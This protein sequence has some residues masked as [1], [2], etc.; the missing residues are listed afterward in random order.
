MKEEREREKKNAK[1]PNI[2][3]SKVGQ[4]LS[5]LTT[6]RVIIIV[7]CIMISIPLFDTGTYSEASTS[8]DLGLSLIYRN[9]PS[10]IALT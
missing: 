8:Y 7:L 4:K 9:Y 3:E 2:T 5:D 10:N 1:S 6:Q